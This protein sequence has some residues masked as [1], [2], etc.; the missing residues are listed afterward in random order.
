MSK[1]V[2]RLV[3]SQLV[4]FFERFRCLLH[5]YADNTQLYFHVTVDNKM[6]Q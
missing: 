5:S 2:E 6:Q 4:T 3:C 1:I